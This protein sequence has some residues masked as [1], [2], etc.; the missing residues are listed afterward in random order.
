MDALSLSFCKMHGLGNDFLVVDNRERGYR[1]APAQVRG[2]GDRRTGVGFDQMLVAEAPAGAGADFAV[3]IFNRDGSE[4]GQCGNG[5]RCMALFARRQGLITTDETL[6][7]A[8]GGPVQARI[9]GDAVSVSLGVPSFEPCAV[10]FLADADRDAHLLD[11][12]GGV[13]ISAG[14]VSVGNPHAVLWVDEV[15]SAAVPEVGPRVQESGRFPEGVNVGFAERVGSARVRLRVYERGAGETR[16]C[17]SGACAAA[18]VG[19]RQGKLDAEVRV[20]L[21]GGPLRVEW[22]GENE[23]V[24]LTGEAA[25][26]FDGEIRL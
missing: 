13:R 16:A 8:P 4:A 22:Q 9:C 7:E 15:A 20:E 25:H 3:R 14:V 10:P 24:W 2:W 26:V 23:P 12:A 18:V 19:R 11:L 1:F 17:G 5:M 6:M 21:P